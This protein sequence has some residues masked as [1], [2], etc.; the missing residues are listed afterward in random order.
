[1][2]IIHSIFQLFFIRPIVWHIQTDKIVGKEGYYA[3]LFVAMWL[4][5]EEITQISKRNFEKTNV[6]YCQIVRYEVWNLPV[7]LIMNIFYFLC[8]KCLFSIS[9]PRQEDM[10]RIFTDRLGNLCIECMT[11]VSLYFY[12]VT[13]SYLFLLTI[14][15]GPFVASTGMIRGS[16]VAT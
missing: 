14:W 5:M 9:L 1:M 10:V 3:T 12:D 16:I 6:R 8:F 7:L 15:L 2:V 4:N 13:L 11:S